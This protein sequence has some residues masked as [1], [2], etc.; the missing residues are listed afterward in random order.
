MIFGV[1]GP[2][3]SSLEGQNGADVLF[4]MAID[5]IVDFPDVDFELGL[6]G[7]VLNCGVWMVVKGVEDIGL[8]IGLNLVLK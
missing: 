4:C 3:L 8:C 2:D 1:F 5:G 6:L 7:W